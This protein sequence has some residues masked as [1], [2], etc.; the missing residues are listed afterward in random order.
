VNADHPSYFGG[1]INENFAAIRVALG[2]ADDE[3]WHLSHNGFT[4]EFMY[5]DLPSRYFSELD[6]YR[7]GAD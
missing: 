4:S 6:R 3:P 7:H 2:F 5:D 1:Y